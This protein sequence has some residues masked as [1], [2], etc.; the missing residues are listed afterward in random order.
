M[1]FKKHIAAVAASPAGAAPERLESLIEVPPDTKLGEY[2]L[3]CFVLAKERRTAP[4][5]IAG[6]IAAAMKPDDIIEAI[7]AAGPYVNFRLRATALATTILPAVLSAGDA[8]AAGGASDTVV[9]DYSSPNIAKQLGIGHLRSTVIGNALART[10]RHL[11]TKVVGINHLGDWGTQFGYMIVAWK[12]WGDEQALAA[13]AVT[14]LMDLYVKA[15]APD[16]PELEAAARSEFKKLEEGDAEALALWKR[17]REL[18][19]K[20]FHVFYDELGVTFQ[21]ED[22]EAFFNDKME[23]ALQR[24]AHLTEISEG[25]LVVQMGG[26]KKPA[27]FRKSDGATLYLTRDLAAALYRLETYHPDRLLYVVGQEQKQHFTELFTVLE[28]LDPANKARF[29]HADFGRYRFP[30]GKMSTRS[31]K[32]IKLNDLFDRGTELALETIEKKNP[33]LEGKPKVARQVALGAVIF[34]DIANDRIK[35]IVFDWDKAL[36]FD[37]DTAPYVMFAHVRARGILRKLEEEGVRAAAGDLKPEALTHEHERRLL[38][39]VGQLREVLE[40][41]GRTLKPHTLAQYLL[42][43]AR[44]YHRFCH[45][46]PVL[47]AEPGV[48]EARLLL[49]QACATVLKLGMTLLGVP[50]PDRM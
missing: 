50:A 39:Q 30:E 32:I 41:V 15:N 19:L 20:E 5:K 9:I 25:A 21:S 36:D 14:H 45:D 40:Q 6:E 10:L 33:D 13:D 38:V 8:Y 2:A 28:K 47:R 46:C 22:G 37:G 3:P 29:V 1:S 12:R 42:D 35:D 17:F 43:L 18:S 24:I 23:P 44:T 26:E 7:T 11:G 31:G 34:N 49:T 4:P 27:L 16:Q 48:R